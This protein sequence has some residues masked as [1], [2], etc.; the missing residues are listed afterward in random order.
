[1]FCEVHRGAGGAHQNAYENYWNYLCFYP[2]RGLTEHRISNRGPVLPTLLD[3]GPRLFTTRPLG[4]NGCFW[5]TFPGF[6]PT[7]PGIPP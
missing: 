1:M 2:V 7:K 6:D 3:G 4:E 5:T